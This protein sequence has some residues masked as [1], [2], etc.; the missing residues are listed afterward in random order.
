MAQSYTSSPNMAAILANLLKYNFLS[1]AHVYP[2][3]L[4]LLFN[5]DD[6]MKLM[7]GQV[8]VPWDLVGMSSPGP[9]ASV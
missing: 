8:Q 3:P 1:A 2:P 4:E 9:V 6:L 5:W 7:E